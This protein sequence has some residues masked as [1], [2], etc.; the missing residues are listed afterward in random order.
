MGMAF[1]IAGRMATRQGMKKCQ[2]RLMEPIMK[3][4]VISPE[5]FMGG[6]VGDISSRRGIINEL[7][8]R[9]NMKTIDA[10][11]PLANMFQYV[12]ALRSMSKGRAQYSMVFDKYEMVPPNVQAELTAKYK[13]A[14]AEDLL[15]DEEAD[16]A[17]TSTLAQLSC[18]VAGAGMLVAILAGLRKSAVVTQVPL[19]G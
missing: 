8:E 1:E 10:R 3:V 18:V 19:L 6:I 4:D 2:A 9:G 11:I 13:P 5:E 14:M 17:S 7:G 15:E 12:S 16:V